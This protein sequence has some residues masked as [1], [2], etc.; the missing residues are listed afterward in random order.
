MPIIAKAGLVW[1]GRPR[2]RG[3]F[4][5]FGAS[6]LLGA[7]RALSSVPP[8]RVSHTPFAAPDAAR[9]SES[10]SE[11]E[12]PDQGDHASTHATA[13][14][15]PSAPCHLRREEASWKYERSP[16]RTIP[17]ARRESGTPLP[18][19]GASG[20]C[21]STTQRLARNVL[22]QKAPSARVNN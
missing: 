8:P 12:V 6:Q 7:S 19:A 4:L 22:G 5:G 10:S 15:S 20:S 1:R 2:P 9:S 3:L 18:P 13:T 16:S 21:S 11:R 14:L 17:P